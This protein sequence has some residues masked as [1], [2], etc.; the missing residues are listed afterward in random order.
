MAVMGRITAP[1]GVTV[2]TVGS[3]EQ[4]VQ[5]TPLEIPAEGIKASLAD[6][7]LDDVQEAYGSMEDDKVKV[8]SL[9]Q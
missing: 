1:E 9:G 7:E 3:T 5:F 4:G 6:L 8:A 2:A